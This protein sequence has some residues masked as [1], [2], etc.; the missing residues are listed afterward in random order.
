MVELF[1]PSLPPISSYLEVDRANFRASKLGVFE[2]YIVVSASE[3]WWARID[4]ECVQGRPKLFGG[5]KP[6]LKLGPFF[7]FFINHSI[8]N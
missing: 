1:R 3:H 5:L 8:L 7:F 2:I 6:K 4:G